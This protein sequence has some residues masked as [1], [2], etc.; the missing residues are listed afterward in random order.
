[1]LYVLI[2]QMSY[3]RDG[4]PVVTNTDCCAFHRLKGWG[5]VCYKLMLFVNLHWVLLLELIK[6][7]ISP[8]CR[9]LALIH[10]QLLQNPDNVLPCTPP[11]MLAKSHPN[12]CQWSIMFVS[13]GPLS[14]PLH[15]PQLQMGITKMLY[16]VKICGNLLY[17]WL[18]MTKSCRVVSIVCV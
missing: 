15:Q 2:R 9:G 12:D 1:M 3:I 16:L 7:L 4:L 13:G 14:S 8:G 11:F 18:V 5:I 10:S 17:S 6:S